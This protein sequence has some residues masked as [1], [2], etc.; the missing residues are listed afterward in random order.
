MNA[1][2]IAKALVEPANVLTDLPCESTQAGKGGEGG[3]FQMTNIEFIAAIYPQ[4]P[5]GAF[6]AVCSKS[7]NPDLG[8]WL[9]SRSDQLVGALSA[10][11]NNYFSCASFYPRDDGSFKARKT[12]F[13]ACHFLMLDDL[14]TKVPLDR[15]DGFELSWLIET[16]PGNHQGGIILADPVTDGAV[17]VRLLTAIIDAGLCDPGATGPLS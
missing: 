1:E 16:S 9:A 11:N 3:D 17:A 5:E 8:G 14:G 15:L 4:L 10:A 12:H 13:A 7:G 6:A 2:T